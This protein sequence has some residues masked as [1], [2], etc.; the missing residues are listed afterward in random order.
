MSD[1]IYTT[2]LPSNAPLH[3]S[4][5]PC[6]PSPSPPT[7][8]PPELESPD[9]A[10]PA[11]EPLPGPAYPPTPSQAI[12]I[13]AEGKASLKNASKPCEI[14]KNKI[15]QK[16]NIRMKNK[17][18]KDFFVVKTSKAEKGQLDLA[19]AKCIYATNSPF[20]IV[21]N[22]SFRDMLS[23]LRPGYT[24]P[25][26]H[27]I[28]EELLNKTYEEVMK[29]Y[30]TTLRG[31]T[32]CM[33]IDGWSNIHNESVICVS[34][35]SEGKSYIIDSIDYE[36]QHTGDNLQII[37]QNCI[38]KAKRLYDCSTASV[39]TDNA[40]N[41]CKMRRQLHT[42]DFI[43]TYGCSAHLLNLL[44]KD[45]E[46]EGTRK[47]LSDVIKY[48]R[49]HHLQAFKLKKYG[50]KKLTLPADTRWNT[51][52]DSMESYLKN[53]DVLEQVCLDESAN[54]NAGITLKVLSAEFS[55]RVKKYLRKLKP[56][57]VALDKIQ[58]ENTLISEC[59]EIWIEMKDEVLSNIKEKTEEM[60]VN[61]RYA[62][63]IT[64]GHCLAN[65]LDPR[66]QGR[67]L[68]KEEKKKG[69]DLINQICPDFMQIY[70]KY[71][72]KIFPF[73]SQYFTNEVIHSMSPADWWKFFEPE[74][75]DQKEE[76]FPRMKLP[77]ML[78]TAVAS[79]AGIERIFSMYGLVQSK[80][81]NRLNNDKAAKLVK[82]YTSLNV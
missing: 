58:R 43:L 38:R 44:V 19:V 28:G 37:M 80:I 21:E 69:T 29:E 57:S 22:D 76:N 49:N 24:P 78:F 70:M 12:C 61:E 59:A 17:S 32:V 46:E 62:T 34:V 48:F 5:L 11:P 47:E 30:D 42:E 1:S 40:S 79:S 67:R 72:A 36:P 52:T 8:C 81:R 65:M 35:T 56:I 20:Q 13:K 60:K 66:Y 16:E 26:R 3:A 41:M 73:C 51:I 31:K 9:A 77:R 6:L 27:R 75:P 7:P 25:D 53:L 71:S 2:A 39:V 50:G 33:S 14:N 55:Q 74:F 15:A 82:I 23:K 45:L 68:S 4:A 64:D 10:A 54:V 63:A 18:M